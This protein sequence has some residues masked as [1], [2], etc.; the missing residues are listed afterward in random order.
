MFQISPST[1]TSCDK[2]WRR[3]IRKFASHQVGYSDQVTN[4]SISSSACF[5]GL[6]DGVCTFNTAAIE[7]AAKPG[8]NTVPKTTYCSSSLLHRFQLAADCPTVL[9][10]QDAWTITQLFVPL[11]G[12]FDQIPRLEARGNRPLQLE[13]TTMEMQIVYD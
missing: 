3:K 7:M 12:S 2:G 6:D 11:N 4:R 5:G 9:T 10:F 13:A 8:Q 1:I